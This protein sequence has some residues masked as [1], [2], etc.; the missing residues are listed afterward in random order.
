CLEAKEPKIQD[1][2][3]LQPHLAG[4]WPAAA[5]AHRAL[6]KK[7][8]SKRNRYHLRKDEKRIH[9]GRTCHHLF[10]MFEEYLRLRQTLELIMRQP[11]RNIK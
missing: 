6:T 7:I 2:A 5:S 9:F 8:F 10:C 1:A 3:K 4:R 11:L